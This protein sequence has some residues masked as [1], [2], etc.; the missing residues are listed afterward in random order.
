M[1]LASLG[2]AHAAP[3]FTLFADYRAANEI[4]NAAGFGLRVALPAENI[5]ELRAEVAAH[6]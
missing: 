5:V 2:R 1:S 4:D 6:F 3:G